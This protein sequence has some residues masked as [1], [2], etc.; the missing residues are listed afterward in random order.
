MSIFDAQEK[1]GSYPDKLLCTGSGGKGQAHSK[2]FKKP[3]RLNWLFA[4]HVLLGMTCTSSFFGH[5]RGRIKPQLIKSLFFSHCSYEHLKILTHFGT[6]LELLSS[7]SG[8]CM[9][10][11]NEENMLGCI[12]LLLHLGSSTPCIDTLH[13]GSLARPRCEHASG[14]ALPGQTL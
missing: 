13:L 14:M 6:S 2:I 10:Q 4:G 5:R 11:S 12:V 7:V 3:K 9:I 8:S 1:P